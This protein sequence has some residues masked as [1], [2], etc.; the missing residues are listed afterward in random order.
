MINNMGVLGSTAGGAAAGTGISPGL[1]TIIGAGIGLVGGIAG[2]FAQNKAN[3]QNIALQ[4]E[5]NELNAKL[6]RENY[7][8]QRDML[9]RNLLYA[10]PMEQRRMLELAGYNAYDFVNGTGS[11]PVAATPT[12]QLPSIQSAQVQPVN[13]FA[14]QLSQFGNQFADVYKTLQEGKNLQ[15][16]TIAKDIDNKTRLELNLQTL[17]NMGLDEEAKLLENEFNQRSLD[18]RLQ[19]VDLDNLLKEATKEL[20]QQQQLEIAIRNKF[21]PYRNFWEV[22]NLV[23]TGKLLLEQGKT[24]ITKQELNRSGIRKNDADALLATVRS[25]YEP[26]VAKSQI[27]ANNASAAYSSAQAANMRTVTDMLKKYGDYENQM[28]IYGMAMDIY[29]GTATIADLNKHIDYLENQMHYY[30]NKGQVDVANAFNN[31]ITSLRDAL[32]SH[33]NPFSMKGTGALLREPKVVP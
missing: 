4:R 23:H 12:P 15:S 25:V 26:N 30:E 16:D 10:S 13:S 21:A 17:R 27:N 1:G 11:K 8:L 3:E 20:T 33:T 18:G 5:T 28:K 9:E 6:A 19:A 2:N 32:E 22:Q 29:E 14:S 31:Y 24:E 7:Q